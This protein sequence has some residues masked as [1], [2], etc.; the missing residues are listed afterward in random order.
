MYR[1]TPSPPPFHL[2]ALLLQGGSNQRRGRGEG[3]SWGRRG[4]VRS[5]ALPLVGRRPSSTSPS[6]PPLLPDLLIHL[7]MK[8]R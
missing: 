2:P 7:K 6:P 3:G 4:D 8:G 5:K 1:T